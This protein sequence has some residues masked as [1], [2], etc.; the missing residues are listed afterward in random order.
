MNDIRSEKPQII[1]SD[2]DQGRLTTLATDALNRYPAVASELLAEMERAQ[3]EP[4][5]SVPSDVVQM[6]STVVFRSDDEQV[7]RVALVFPG[8]ADIGEGKISILT[9]IGTAL[10]GLS[11]GQS[12]TSLTRDGKSRRLTVVSVEGAADALGHVRPASAGQSRKARPRASGASNATLDASGSASLNPGSETDGIREAVAVFATAETLQGAIDELLSSGFHRAQLSL[13]ASERELVAKLGHKYRRSSELAD[14]VSVP[15]AAYVSTEAIG[16][17]QGAAIGALMY[18]GAGVLMGPAAAAG[19][20][21]AAMLAA[22]A[23]GGG[24]GGLIGA[25]LANLLGDWHANRIVEQLEHGGLLLWVRTWDA[26]QESR[27]VRVLERNSGRDVHV[28][29]YHAGIDR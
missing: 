27:A 6:G 13:L 1:V 8:Q 23:L 3:V 22:A 21:I 17:G 12:I 10:I 28:H 16:D 4:A 7:R 14:D 9:P 19:G 29:E 26:G 20:T 18:I 25:L 24:A 2:S 5:G 15:R 11:E